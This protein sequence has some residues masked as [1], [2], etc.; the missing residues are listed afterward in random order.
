ML[1]SKI[2]VK[3][4]RLGIIVIFIL[5]AGLGIWG[6]QHDIPQKIKNQFAH[7]IEKY[8]VFTNQGL[9]RDDEKISQNDRENVHDKP[10]SQSSFD[11]GITGFGQ[12]PEQHAALAEDNRSDSNG[13]SDN[14]ELQ[15]VP[16]NVSLSEITDIGQGDDVGNEDVLAASD[17]KNQG[18]STPLAKDASEFPE[19]IQKRLEFDKKR[20]QQIKEVFVLRMEAMEYLECER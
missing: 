18:R 6:L 8:G 15:D 13:L 2:H 1:P 4:S 12:N 16:G 11:T 7:Q 14:A 20:A 10:T 5:G 19:S 17:G 9:P 3:P